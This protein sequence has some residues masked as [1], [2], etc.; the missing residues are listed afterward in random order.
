MSIILVVIIFIGFFILGIR[1]WSTRRRIS[2]VLL[3]PAFLILLSI[4]YGVF[5]SWY[6]TEPNLL[7]FSVQKENQVYTVKGVWEKPLDAYRFPTDF[8]IFYVPNNAEITYV[9]R[10]RVKDYKSMDPKFLEESIKEWISK[11]KP[12][13]SP[14]QIFDIE[15][16]K[17]F[18]FSF[19]LPD[20]VKA[21]DVKIYYAH[22]REEPMDALEF[23]FKKI[24][25]K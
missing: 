5:N 13:K 23:W 16:S 4:G 3:I 25:L 14:P 7:K 12:P 20:N 19:I 22:T 15:T 18:S 2:L 11:E 17:K 21:D 24:E 6:H 1:W 8:I 10:N 9:K